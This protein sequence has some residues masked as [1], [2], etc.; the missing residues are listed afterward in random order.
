MSVFGVLSKETKGPVIDQGPVRFNVDRS[1]GDF[2]PVRD[3]TEKPRCGEGSFLRP[4]F[5]VEA[6]GSPFKD[7]LP[8]I[9]TYF[10]IPNPP[11]SIFLDSENDIR[12]SKIIKIDCKS[13]SALPSGQRSSRNPWLGHMTDK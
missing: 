4:K 1:A 9:M 12:H 2:D 6:P 5:V 11:V 13:H 8:T 10:Q 7:Q 3:R